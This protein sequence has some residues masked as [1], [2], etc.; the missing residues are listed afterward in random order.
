VEGS[1]GGGGGLEMRG[2]VR[3]MHSAAL[4]GVDRVVAASPQALFD[5]AADVLVLVLRAIGTHTHTHTHTQRSPSVR[6]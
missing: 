5:R 4:V 6:G 1:S 2:G 3:G